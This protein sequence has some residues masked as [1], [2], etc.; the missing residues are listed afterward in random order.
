MNSTRKMLRNPP[1]LFTKTPPKTPPTPAFTAGGD[2]VKVAK[3]PPLC[4]GRVCVATKFLI[5]HGK[6]GQP[7]FTPTNCHRRDRHRFGGGESTEPPAP[8][9]SLIPGRGW[10]RKTTARSAVGSTCRRSNTP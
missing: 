4:V 3:I 1:I 8:A 2:S 7:T 9:Q 10:G 5:S 6:D